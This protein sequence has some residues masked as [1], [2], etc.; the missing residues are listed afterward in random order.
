MARVFVYPALL[1]FSIMMGGLAFA[2]EAGCEL[3]GHLLKCGSGSDVS[4]VNALAADETA[5]LF[6]EPIELIPR[7][8]QPWKTERFRKSLERNRRALRR[9]ELRQRVKMR[10]G[11]ISRDAFKKWAETYDAAQANYE[12]G[13]L[14]YRTLIWHGKGGRKARVNL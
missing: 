7:F 3:D 8:D 12:R 11:I 13:V 6:E 2:D 4:R 5:Q 14:V 9:V 1:A 10:R